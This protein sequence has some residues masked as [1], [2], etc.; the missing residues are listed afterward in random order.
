[1]SYYNGKSFDQMA[2]CFMALFAGIFVAIGVTIGLV[3]GYLIWGG[4]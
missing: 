2:V 3:V 4:A 1:V